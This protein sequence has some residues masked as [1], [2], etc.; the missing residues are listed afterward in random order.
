MAIARGGLTLGHFIA[1]G[2]NIR[3]LYSI[4]SIHYDGD[5]KLD[6]IEIFNT[7]D[8]KEAKRVLV[9]DDIV[10]SGETMSEVLRILRKDYPEVEF[11]VATLFY[12]KEA[13]VKA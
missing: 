6:Y 1:I 4:N 2:L 5:R 12:K 10:D 11:K 3:S 8:I 7:P 13:L 9:V